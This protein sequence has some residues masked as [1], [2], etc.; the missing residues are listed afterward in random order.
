DDPERLARLRSGRALDA[1]DRGARAREALRNSGR[2]VV[3]QVLVGL[4]VLFFLV[5]LAMCMPDGKATNAFFI[6]FLAAD[7][8]RADDVRQQTGGL[9]FDDLVRGQW[10]RLLTCCFVHYGIIHL[11]MNMYALW[12]LG[13]QMERILGWWQYLIIYL[14]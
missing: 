10:W 8:P 2:P 13:G 4:N 9:R 5:G 3:T 11:G 7:N 12:R 1:E 14:L 6:G